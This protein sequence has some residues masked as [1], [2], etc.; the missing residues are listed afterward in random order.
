MHKITCFLCTKMVRR[1][2]ALKGLEQGVGMWFGE[3][4]V[5]MFS[6]LLQ[7]KKLVLIADRLYY[8]VQHEGQA[9]K[10]YDESLWENIIHL[11]SQYQSMLPLGSNLDG[12]RKRT[13]IYIR[14]TISEKMIPSGISREAFV[15][16]ISN[17]RKHPYID[18]FFRPAMIR[19]GWKNEFAYWLLKMRLFRS[20]FTIF[21]NG[22]K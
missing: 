3:D 14:N 6:M 5:S 13:W 12:L 1:K 20:F 8:Y 7:C 11:L 18:T 17:V 16:Q 19:F 10:R 9:V 22:L 2:Y 15:S 4:Q 21:V